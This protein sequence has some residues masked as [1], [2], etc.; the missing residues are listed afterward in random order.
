[1]DYH[2]FGSSI[3]PNWL[4]S[5]PTNVQP[6]ASADGT[7]VP[8]VSV[9]P[10]PEVFTPTIATPF[11]TETPTLPAPSA[12]AT[13]TPA[14]TEVPYCDQ[15]FK[16]YVPAE[17]FKLYCD[18]LFEFAFEYPLGWEVDGLGRP[19]PNPTTQP[20]V[21]PQRLMF[22]SENKGNFV[23]FYTFR[24][25]QGATLRERL[26]EEIFIYGAY[27]DRAFRK[28]YSPMRIGGKPA[29]GFVN[30]Y[31]QAYNACSLLFE[32]GDGYYTMVELK[33]ISRAKLDVNWQIARSI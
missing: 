30:R 28:D 25:P 8:Q 24:M 26:V 32:H 2:P 29:Y 23:S 33:I 31:G 4:Q 9:S 27:A 19:T 3:E 21:M 14:P 11:V 13:S 15:L 10:S 12:T 17:A 5:I 6:I 1:V 20:Q 16:S 22:Y 18:D 7:A